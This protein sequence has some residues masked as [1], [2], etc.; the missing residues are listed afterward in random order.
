MFKRS[1]STRWIHSWPKWND[2]SAGTRN[3][4]FH[5]STLHASKRRD[6]SLPLDSSLYLYIFLFFFSFVRQCDAA[7]SCCEFG[8]TFPTRGIVCDDLW[9]HSVRTS[10]H[11]RYIHANSRS[12]L[13]A[14]QDGIAALPLPLPHES[15]WILISDHSLIFG[16][17]RMIST[18]L[19][20]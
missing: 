20:L 4:G 13:E 8:S 11:H 16:V 9:L 5:S 1:G 3:V 18:L 15:V 2:V 7:I 10:Q 19:W 12:M 17:I 14:N 6:H